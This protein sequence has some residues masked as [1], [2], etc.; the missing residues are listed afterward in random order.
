MAS[1]EII[2]VPA[3]DLVKPLMPKMLDPRVSVF[4]VL[5]WMIMRSCPFPLCRMPPVMTAAWL[6]TAAVSRMPPLLTVRISAMVMLEAP[7][8]LKRMELTVLAEAVVPVKPW[9]PLVTLAELVPHAEASLATVSAPPI[10]APATMF[11][12]ITAAQSVIWLNVA[13]PPRRDPPGVEVAILVLLPVSIKS[14]VP[15]VLREI[16]PKASVVGL[17]PRLATWMV[18]PPE[19]TVKPLGASVTGAD[20]F[21][22]ICRRPPPMINELEL[23]SIALVVEL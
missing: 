9:L 8:P 17:A 5:F 22:K 20:E 7:A 16:A 14:T 21:P 11:P 12:P 6:P 23:L 13:H 2:N 15:P 1:P 3:P 10:V 4:A 19:F 18:D